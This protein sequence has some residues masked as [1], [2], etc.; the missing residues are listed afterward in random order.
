MVESV[1]RNAEW[2]LFVGVLAN[3]AG[4]PV[5]I[6]PWLLAAGVLAASGHLSLVGIVAGAAGAALGADL[7]WYGLGRW[8][9]AEALTRLLGALRQPPATVDRVVRVFRAHRFGFVWTARFLPELNPIAAGLSGV[10]GVGLTRFLLYASG[11]AFTW[12]G[13]WVGAGF[14]LAGTLA[15]SP[16][17]AES[18]A[19]LI[20]LSL[21]AVGVG[22]LGLLEWRRRRRLRRDVDAE[23]TP[24]VE[25]EPAERRRRVQRDGAAEHP[26]S[27][28]ARRPL[29]LA[30][31]AT[32]A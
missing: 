10:T 1:V 27:P 5:P 23:I 16:D 3:Q 13:V 18:A 6:A 31:R 19:G 29:D 11:S 15:G 14:L 28:S 20:A 12:V 17:A 8:R 25:L 32:A 9:G 21:T 22:M 26:A 24:V 4:I 30:E 7:G 2:L